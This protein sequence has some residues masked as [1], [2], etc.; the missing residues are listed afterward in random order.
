MKTDEPWVVFEVEASGMKRPLYA[1]EIAAQRMRGFETDGVRFRVLLNHVISLD[2]GSQAI[3]G[4]TEDY[5]E[6]GKAPP[7]PGESESE[8]DS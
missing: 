2:P 7:R 3:H 5:L 8:P 4:Y 6:T 1:V